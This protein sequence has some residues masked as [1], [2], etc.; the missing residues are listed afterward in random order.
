MFIKKEAENLDFKLV[1]PFKATGDQPQA[2][3]KLVEGINRGDREQTLL[4]IT[5]SGKTFTMASVIEKINRPTIVLSHNK[6]LAAQLCSEFKE[7]FPENS[8]EYF[9]SY[10]DYYQP[11]AYIASTDT[12]IE[13]TSDINDEIEKLRHSAT[14]ALSERRDVIIVASVSCI[15]TLGDPID[16]RTMVLSLRPGMQKERDEVITQLVNMQYERN[17]MNLIRNK[18]RVRGDVIEICPAYSDEKIFRIEFFGDEVDRITEIQAVTGEVK[19]VLNHVSIYPA[20]HYIVPKDKM[21]KAVDEIREECE[22]RVKYFKEKGKLIEA[23]RIEERTNY[24]MEMLTEVGFCKGIENYS[25]VL[26][27]RAP[28]SCPTTL[29]DYF[30]EDFVLFIDESHVTLPQVRAMSGGDRSRKENLIEYGFR[31]PSAI[32]NRPLTF[33]E[34]DG[35]LNQI[36]YVSATPGQ[37]EKDRSTQKVEQVIRP[38]GLLDPEISVRPVEGQIEDLLS[39][40]NMRVE[41]GE[42][43][44]ITTLTKKMA[45]NLTDYL[46]QMGVKV[47]YM[48]HDIDTIERMEIIRDLRLGEFDVLCGINLLREGLD[49]PEVSL[50]AI[51]DA[52][53]EGFLRSETSLI[54]TIGRAARNAE[55]KVIMYADTVTESM[56]KAITETER[57]RK[58]QDAYNKE[59]GIVPKTIKKDVRDIIEISSHKD[60]EKVGKRRLSYKETE[61]EIKRLTNEMKAASKILEFEHAAYL[62]DRIKKLREQLEDVQY[63]SKFHRHKGSK[64]T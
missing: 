13:K 14:A 3:E 54:Q 34:F 38:T 4:G 22:E 10:Y 52:D 30:P 45:E 46:I 7:F 15:Y 19:G 64:G 48:H 42:R 24:D 32:D 41:K 27:G 50:V 62:R 60:D 57:R 12:Y 61:E 11:E 31:L 58:I 44:L 63:E 28:G 55:G 25:R 56:E 47:R 51:L 8:V 18:F 35:K 17:D 53:K 39:E 40:I 9:V 49:I 33:D 36:I 5:G 6:T 2:I 16:Y 29:L 1:S 20:S 23:Q 26:S 43:T 21:L 59:H 37:Y